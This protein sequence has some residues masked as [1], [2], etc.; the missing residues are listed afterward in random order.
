MRNM[1]LIVFVLIVVFLQS[2]PIGE[3]TYFILLRN[4]ASYDVGYYLATNSIDGPTAYPDTSLPITNF[5][6]GSIVAPK[7][8]AV[9]AESGV[10]WE[11]YMKEI[12]PVD[13]LS[14]FI[15]HADTLNKYSW[16]EIRKNYKVLRRYDMSIDDLKRTKWRFIHTE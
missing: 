4:D 10:K 16:E 9:I 14:I 5:D 6:L 12:L 8:E 13:T 15:F 3:P 11:K 1:T 7:T 2:C